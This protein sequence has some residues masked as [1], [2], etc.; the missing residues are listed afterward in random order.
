MPYCQQIIS[1]E[2]KLKRLIEVPQTSSISNLKYAI[3]KYCQVTKKPVFIIN[4][5]DDL[6]CSAAFVHKNKDLSGEFKK[7]P[8]GALHDF[9]IEN[10][11]RCDVSI[12]MPL[13]R[14]FYPTL[15]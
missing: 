9:L 6:I 11:E 15:F 10:A 8:G 14:S 1:G 5:P 13:N 2:A 4:S 12:Y 3:N 7:G